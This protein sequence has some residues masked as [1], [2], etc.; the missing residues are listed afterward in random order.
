MLLGTARAQSE[1]Y[2]SSLSH[3]ERRCKSECVERNDSSGVSAGQRSKQE[4]KRVRVAIT[5]TM[6]TKT[7][8]NNEKMTDGIVD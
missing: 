5:M 6:K 2:S 3:V 8:V 1:V 7:R 4:E